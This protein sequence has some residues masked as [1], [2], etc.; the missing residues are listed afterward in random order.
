MTFPGERSRHTQC[1][2]SLLT[3]PHDTAH[4]IHGMNC[5]VHYTCTACKES[6]CNKKHTIAYGELRKGTS[7]GQ[8]CTLVSGF[9]FLGLFFFLLLTLDAR[10]FFS[11]SLSTFLSVSTVCT[12][13]LVMRSEPF[14]MSRT[15]A[16]NC[17]TTSPLC[18]NPPPEHP[19]V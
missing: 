7:I 18:T 1:L 8:G 10:S 2:C 13:A 4:S 19:S 11:S 14:G 12:G 3:L 16:L 6:R 5:H 9:F 15:V 17:A